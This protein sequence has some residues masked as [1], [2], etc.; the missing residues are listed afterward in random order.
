VDH[1]TR[2]GRHYP[3]RE[4]LLL[5][6]FRLRDGY[7]AFHARAVAGRLGWRD[8]LVAAW[9][10][11]LRRQRMLRRTMAGFYKLTPAGERRLAWLDK[12]RPNK[13]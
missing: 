6:Q 5:D 10:S 7:N 9:I 8:N 4:H 11:Y 12:N 3:K 13:G 2:T 1:Y